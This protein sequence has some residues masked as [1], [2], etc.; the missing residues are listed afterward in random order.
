[1]QMNRWVELKVTMPGMEGVQ[2]I[3]EQTSEIQY[4]TEMDEAA[5]KLEFTVYKDKGLNILEGSEVSLR[6]HAPDYQRNVFW[7]K[8]FTKEKD[9]WGK[10]KVTAYDQLR[11]LK[12]NMTI[13][14][15]NI[16]VSDIIRN[17]GLKFGVNVGELHQNNNFKLGT[18]VHSAKSG[19]QIL[20]D[21]IGKHLANTGEKLVVY[22]D[23]GEIKMRPIADMVR[24]YDIIG[25]QSRV[26]D[27]LYK[28]SID[29]NVYN[30]IVLSYGDA[31]KGKMTTMVTS[32]PETMEVW[33]PLIFHKVWSENIN[34]AQLQSILG[35]LLDYHNRKTRLLTLNKVEGIV[36]LRGGNSIMVDIEGL[37]DINLLQSMILDKV[38]HTFTR[39][40][41]WMDIEGK[42]IGPR[43]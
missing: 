23:F 33:G 9:K 20:S 11:Y 12:S 40:S 7:G 25:Y 32:D 13:M 3:T 10:I 22:D 43:L 27:Y 26:T 37:G 8:I 5:G 34:V 2:D 15:Q 19:L 17:I 24:M 31:S 35:N 18:F 29:D 16:T 1:M 42:V 14:Q 30:Q 36:G 6:V 28:T 4:T 21:A 38:K 41:H 39:G